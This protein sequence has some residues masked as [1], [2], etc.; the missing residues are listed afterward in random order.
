MGFLSGNI[1][2]FHDIGGLGNMKGLFL[3]EFMGKN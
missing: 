1:E 3:D 2:L